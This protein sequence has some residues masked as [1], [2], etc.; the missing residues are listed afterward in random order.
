MER[1]G[2]LFSGFLLAILLAGCGS[3]GGS[4]KDKATDTETTGTGNGDWLQLS[5][6]RLNVTAHVNESIYVH[7]TGTAL[8]L[9]DVEIDDDTPE[10]QVGI[11]DSTD[12]FF[13]PRV[14]ASEDGNRF[15]LTLQ[16]FWKTTTGRHTGTLEI[17]VCQ[18]DPMVCSKPYPGSP[19][20]LPF[21]L[22]VREG[23]KSA[24][25]SVSGLVPWTTFQGNAAHT[26]H[27]AASFSPASFNTRW[28]R[29]GDAGSKGDIAH[30]VATINGMTIASY[31]NYQVSAIS[32]DSG[33]VVWEQKLPAPGT[34]IPGNTNPP[35]VANGKVH[36]STTGYENTFMW[37]LDLNT[38]VIL[39]QH[40][41]QSQWVVYLA[42]TAHGNGVYTG[43][44][45]YGGM[46]KFDLSSN[47][48]S[49]NRGGAQ[50]DLWTPAADDSYVYTHTGGYLNSI[51][52]ADGKT[53]FSI[54][55]PESLLSALDIPG[56][57]VIA[58][59]DRVC[60]V[61]GIVSNLI[62]MDTF[63]RKLAWN[64]ADISMTTPAVAHGVLYTRT[65]KAVTARKVSDGTLLW[66]W[67]IPEGQYNWRRD[68]VLVTDNLLFVSTA[69][70]VHAIDLQTHETVWRYPQSGS[71]AI[72]E[73]GVLYIVSH[74]GTLVAINLQ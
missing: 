63:N 58:A 22:D 14:V 60:Y 49:W 28:A 17:R 11:F 57:P 9:P 39:A 72:S 30:S 68:P 25:S 48:P 3:G 10:V 34:T 31:R 33:T 74:T 55:N 43:S 2:S 35:A 29:Y 23:N 37:A 15:F 32:E 56:A 1:P 50:S 70:M 64:V 67:P 20:K 7:V 59:A 13:S 5:P 36:V 66:S 24:L 62:C 8:E 38:G 26:G 54:K 12:T 73:Q 53:V 69:S 18:D 4:G 45:Y 16:T 46:S 27:V 6:S 40:A 41:M 44:G 71:L 19:W 47:Q 61:Q 52:P 42:P 51:A 21:Q 65:N